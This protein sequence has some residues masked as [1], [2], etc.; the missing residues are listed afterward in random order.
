MNMEIEIKAV[1]K[2]TESIDKVKKA[3]TNIFPSVILEEREGTL[4]GKATKMDVF[5]K[6]L[7][8]QRIRD[9]AKSFLQKRAKEKE[10]S[11]VLN[12]EA[13]Y[14]GKV[15]FLT[16]EHPM[17]GIEVVV[18]TDDISEFINWLTEKNTQDKK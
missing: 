9:T 10:V 3:I 12:K 5:K 17:G 1:V 6:M 18:R 8:I 13:A 15:N 16:V 11:F 7:E 2:K 14:V 4:I